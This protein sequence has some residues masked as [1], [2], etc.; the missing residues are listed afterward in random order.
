MCMG[1]GMKNGLLSGIVS[2]LKNSAGMKITPLGKMLTKSG[3]MEKSVGK[4]FN[5]QNRAGNKIAKAVSATPTASGKN[6]PKQLKS[7]MKRTLLGGFLNG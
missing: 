2:L 5:I 7:V 4:D 1:S 3:A 6:V